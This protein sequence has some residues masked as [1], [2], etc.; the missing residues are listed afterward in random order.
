MIFRY[1]SYDRF[2]NGQE[3]RLYDIRILK[4]IFVIAPCELTRNNKVNIAQRIRGIIQGNGKHV[5]EWIQCD[6]NN[7]DKK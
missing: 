2:H 6:D 7:H 4:Y 1:G 3:E 5:Q